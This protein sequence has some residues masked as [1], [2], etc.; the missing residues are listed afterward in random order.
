MVSCSTNHS[1]PPKL[2]P[3]NQYGNNHIEYRRKGKPFCRKKGVT[4]MKRKQIM[5]EILN[6]K[7]MI[8]NLKRNISM[9]KVQPMMSMYMPPA[10]PAAPPPPPPPPPGGLGK[11]KVVKVDQM[12]LDRASL[13]NNLKKKLEMRKKIE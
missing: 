5:N 3:C 11:S 7:G 8:I 4:I 13:M 9:I 6:L 1:S 2:P 12:M 10:A